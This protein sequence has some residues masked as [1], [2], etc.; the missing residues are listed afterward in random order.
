MGLSEEGVF[1]GKLEEGTRVTIEL[2]EKLDEDRRKVHLYEEGDFDEYWGFEVSRA[3]SLAQAL[4]KTK[5]DYIIGT[6]RRGQNIHESFEGIKADDLDG[7]KVAFGGPLSG[8]LR[9]L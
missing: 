8:A 6:S 5:S 4:S 7:L 1:E 3:D 9:D 2:G